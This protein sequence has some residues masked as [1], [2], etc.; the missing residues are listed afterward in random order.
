MCSGAAAG[1]RVR[2]P[3]CAWRALRRVR[4]AGAGRGTRSRRKEP[5]C[6]HTPGI[7][8]MQGSPQVARSEEVRV[9]SYILGSGF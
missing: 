5:K 3:A 1:M 9:V 7:H 8:E 4:G 6:V 2:G